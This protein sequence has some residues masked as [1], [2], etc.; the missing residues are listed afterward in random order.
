MWNTRD[1]VHRLSH[2]LSHS[3]TLPLSHSPT[4]QLCTDKVDFIRDL[5]ALGIVI[6]A[7]V[8]VAF[9]GVVSC[10]PDLTP[11]RNL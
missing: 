5:V 4:L 10:W 8:M 6:S 2:Q 9:D 7:V 3:A 1:R 11:H